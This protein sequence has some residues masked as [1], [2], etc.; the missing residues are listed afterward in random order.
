MSASEASVAG[1]RDLGPLDAQLLQSGA[2]DVSA[3]AE[4]YDGVA[5]RIY[6]LALRVLGDVHQS[7]EV[8]Q[9]V[10]LQIWQTAARF[11]PDRGSALS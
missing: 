5:P 7:E 4:L 2:G 3:F 9:E 11:D 6:G 8:S 1:H 10:F